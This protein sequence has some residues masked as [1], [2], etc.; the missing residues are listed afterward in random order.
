MKFW[1]KDPKTN[2]YSVTVTLLTITFVIALIK[3]L[4][5]GVTISGFKMNNFGGTD[6]AA[7]VGAVGA[8]Y[9]WRKKTD[10]D[11]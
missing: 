4:I 6:F 5:S 9:G 8:I 10:K 11:K 1:L 2:E 7:M 3:V